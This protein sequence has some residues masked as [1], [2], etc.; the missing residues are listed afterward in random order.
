MFS[1][2]MGRGEERRE[3]IALMACGGFFVVYLDGCVCL[4]VGEVEDERRRRRRKRG[5]RKRRRKKRGGGCIY[6]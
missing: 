4:V 1:A 2:G 5:R 3:G 6:K